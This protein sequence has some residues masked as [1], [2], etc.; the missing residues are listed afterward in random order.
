MRFKFLKTAFVSTILAISSFVNAGIID[1]NDLNVNPQTNL[2]SP[3]DYNGLTF[4]GIHLSSFDHDTWDM[5]GDGTDFL[6]WAT[7]SNL[8]LSTTNGD[9]FELHS[10]QLG[11]LRYNGP[12]GIAQIIGTVQ[13]GGILTRNIT[14][15]ERFTD[16]TLIGWESLLSVSF[17]GPGQWMS[18]DNIS[19]TVDAT[20]VPEPSTLAIFALG[21]VGLASR[22]FKKQ[23]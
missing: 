19:V 10:L 1:F 21:M 22:R 16:V 9:L 2:G 7:G 14:V 13:G 5:N 6:G 18:I 8:G 12:G 4:T 11:Q 20:D 15:A 23:S 3:F 17:T